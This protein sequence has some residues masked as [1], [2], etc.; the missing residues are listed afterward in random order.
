MHVSSAVSPAGAL[1]LKLETPPRATSSAVHFIWAAVLLV[2]AYVQLND[3]DPLIWILA[4]G[5]TALYHL[6][7]ALR[8]AA[9]PRAPF[10]ALPG[11]LLLLSLY[12]LRDTALQTLLSNP[13][14]FEPAREA[15]GMGIALLSLLVPGN[16]AILGLFSVATAAWLGSGLGCI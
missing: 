13:L 12:S 8:A 5:V 14:R 16:V 6:L 9:P 15:L 1:S 2:A 10:A 3:V 11:A 4:Y 7:C